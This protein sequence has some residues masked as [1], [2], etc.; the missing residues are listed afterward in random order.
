[1]SHK[2]KNVLTP[3]FKNLC[4]AYDII[5]YIG[6]TALLLADSDT[7]MMPLVHLP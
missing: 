5:K 1:M 4:T 2:V 3:T 6:F 7:V